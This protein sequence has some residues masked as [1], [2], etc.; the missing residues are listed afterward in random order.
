MHFSGQ[1]IPTKPL[2]GHP[3][4]WFG[5]GIL[6][7]IPFT[8]ILEILVICPD[9]C[10]SSIFSREKSWKMQITSNRNLST[11]RNL[12][13]KGGEAVSQWLFLV[14]LKGGRDYITPQKAIY[15]WY[16]SG[17]YCQ[18]GDYIPPTTLYRNLKNPLSKWRYFPPNMAELP[19]GW[20]NATY[21]EIEVD[22]K[23]Y[24]EPLFDLYFWR[25]TPS[26]QGPFLS[27]QGSF[28]L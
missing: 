8:E 26:K 18:L 9:V 17:I 16:I 21:F 10:F 5:K 23:I 24:L 7:K 20:F 25:S 6:P 12:P 1:T 11:D 15:K 14:P 13:K 27:K 19:R 28:G 2:V 3:I 22:A 4:L